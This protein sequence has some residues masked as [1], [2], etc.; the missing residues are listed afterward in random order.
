MTAMNGKVALIT[1]AATGIGRATAELFAREGAKLVLADLNADLG[2]ALA[3][4]L[5][6]QGAAAHFVA[7]DVAKPADCERMVAAAV[8]KFGRLD[9]AFNNAGVSDGP[10]PPATDAYPLE[11]WDKLIAVNLSGVFYGMRFQLRA[12]LEGGGGS[13]VNT[14]SIAGHIG[15]AGTPGYVASKHG[16]L[17]LTKV[18]AIEYGARGIRCNAVAP[19]FIETPMTHDVFGSDPFKQVVHAA[20]PM[21]RVAE[22]KEVAESVLWLCSDRASYVNGTCLTVDGGYLAQ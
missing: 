15:F 17:G 3:S 1:G 4:E 11:L 19:G 20:V 9:A 8:E 6:A 22:P 10:V 16:V 12:M 18:V 7:T 21:R 2:E 14:A 13:I 5:R